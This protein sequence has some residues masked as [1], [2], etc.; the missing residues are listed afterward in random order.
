MAPSTRPPALSGD[1]SLVPVS[2]RLMWRDALARHVL[3]GL[4]L[5]DWKKQEQIEPVNSTIASL[6]NR[7]LTDPAAIASHIFHMGSVRKNDAAS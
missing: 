3:D 7:G 5:P 4:A 2:E 6:L 1:F